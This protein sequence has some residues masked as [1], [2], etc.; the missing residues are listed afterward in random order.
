[1]ACLGDGLLGPVGGEHD[2]DPAQRPIRD[3]GQHRG[4]RRRVEAVHELV[5][6]QRA[7]PGREAPGEERTPGLAGGDLD[8]GAPPERGEA[9]R[10]DGRVHPPLGIGVEP[11]VRPDAVGETAADHVL[12]RHRPVPPQIGVLGFRRDQRD[13][14]PG[15][16]GAL[17]GLAVQVVG[18]AAAAPGMGPGLAPQEAQEGALAGA[19]PPQEQPALSL[20]E[21]EGDPL[22][23]GA[24]PEP[25]VDVVEGDEGRAQPAL[26]ARVAPGAQGRPARYNR[27]VEAR[28]VEFARLLR[29]NG[30]RVSPAEAADAV[31]AAAAR[32]RRRPAHVPRHPAGHP[33]QAGRRRPGLRPA[34]R[35]L[36]LGALPGDRGAGAIGGARS[37]RRAGRS[38]G[39]S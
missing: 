23:E 35:A 21:R 12:D 16:D 39:T 3:R 2:R 20:A 31:R 38:R 19:V 34:L 24:S 13:P 32:R 17:G 37:S 6:Q 33:G 14:L 15:S 5:E 22:E 28:I 27:A 29:Q 26:H 7:R 11:S 10:T 25:D 9:E 36:L 18:A 30:V 8:H 4:A 1:M